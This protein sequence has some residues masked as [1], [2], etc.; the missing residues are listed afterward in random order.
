MATVVT[1]EVE[2]NFPDGKRTI[3]MFWNKTSEIEDCEIGTVIVLLLTDE[4][5]VTGIFKGIS[6]DDVMIGSF[7]GKHTLGYKTHWVDSY[8]EEIKK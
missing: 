6:G 3:E 2:I 7:D 4:S 8:C 5:N 1:T